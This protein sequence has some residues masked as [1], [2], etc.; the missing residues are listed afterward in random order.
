MAMEHR[1]DRL[2]KSVGGAVT[3]REA[4]WR[5]GG[6]VVLAM[7]ASLGLNAAGRKDTCA[8]CCAVA[9]RNLDPPPRG[10]E[11]ALCITEC[12]ETGVVGG[13]LLC[14]PPFCED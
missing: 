4:F 13:I 9:C 7:L 10:H 1:F 2:A 5:L 14:A 8:K 3:R 11:L 12:H 6:G